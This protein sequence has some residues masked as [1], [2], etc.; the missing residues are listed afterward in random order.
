[1]LKHSVMSFCSLLISA[2]D[3]AKDWTWAVSLPAECSVLSCCLSFCSL[4][5]LRWKQVQA[6]TSIS[7]LPE[8]PVCPQ[9]NAMLCNARRY[10]ELQF[11]NVP[12]EIKGFKKH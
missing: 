7:L 2:P 5:V 10:T 4:R 8:I 11:R 1:M 9:R 12:G 6:N 3:G